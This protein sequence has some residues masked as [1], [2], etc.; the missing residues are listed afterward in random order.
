VPRVRVEYQRDFQGSSDATMSYADLLA[1]PLYRANVGNTARNH[2]LVGIGT[3]AQFNSGL[4]LRVEYQAL[5]D[6]GTHANQSILLGIE[7]TF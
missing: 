1:G 4:S 6:A 7:K 2:A 5:F 3:Q